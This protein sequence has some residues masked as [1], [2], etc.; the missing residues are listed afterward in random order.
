MSKKVSRNPESNESLDKCIL[1]KNS[2]YHIGKA[3]INKYVIFI[4]FFFQDF[5]LRE[6]NVYCAH[7]DLL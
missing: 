4:T 2:W 5:L 6:C 1:Q 7:L 3:P